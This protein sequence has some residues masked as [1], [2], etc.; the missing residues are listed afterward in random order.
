MKYNANIV[1]G[2]GY[3]IFLILMLTSLINSCK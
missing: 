1:A 2:I 3:S